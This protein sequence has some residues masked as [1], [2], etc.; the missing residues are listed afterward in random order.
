MKDYD[1]KISFAIEDLLYSKGIA[2]EKGAIESKEKL[3][4]LVKE[5]LNTWNK[6]INKIIDKQYE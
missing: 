5:Y 2:F 4:E 1:L 6:S 3:K